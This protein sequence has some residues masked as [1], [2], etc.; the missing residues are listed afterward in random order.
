MAVYFQEDYIAELQ[1]KLKQLRS[2]ISNE[3][4]LQALANEKEDY[5][6]IRRLQGELGVSIYIYISNERELHAL[7]NEKEDYNLIRR[8]QGELGV[9]IYIYI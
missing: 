9:S 2:R 6:L 8:L 3:R 4:E 7:A 1:E 5:N